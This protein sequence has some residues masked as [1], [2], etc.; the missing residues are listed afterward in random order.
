MNHRGSIVLSVNSIFITSSQDV[1]TNTF[2]LVINFEDFYLK[3]SES[4]LPFQSTR[5]LELEQLCNQY[6]WFAIN[7]QLY[8]TFSLR[9]IDNFSLQCEHAVK[10]AGEKKKVMYK[11][12]NY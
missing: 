6:K 1:L 4:Y 11:V 8:I 12:K 10:L 7:C 5:V 2:T 3:F 9:P